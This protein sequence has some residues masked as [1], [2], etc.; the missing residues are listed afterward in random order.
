MK[1]KEMTDN[2][3]QPCLWAV[4]VTTASLLIRSSCLGKV[5]YQRANT[6]E[7]IGLLSEPVS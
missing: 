3:L 4:T 2:H 1:G 5:K 6:H 7:G